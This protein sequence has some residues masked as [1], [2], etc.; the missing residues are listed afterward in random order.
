MFELADIFN[1]DLSSW[2]VSNVKN[3]ANMFDAAKSFNQSLASW[4]VSSSTSMEG[5]F[6]ALI[7]ST[8][9]D[10]ECPTTAD[11]NLDAN[12]PGPFCVECM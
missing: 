5:M 7:S 1:Q 12:P 8:F 11:A 10:T 2:D 4:D 3:F 6:G 9:A